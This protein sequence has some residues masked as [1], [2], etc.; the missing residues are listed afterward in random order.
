M[1]SVVQGIQR[2]L[3]RPQ[4]RATSFLPARWGLAAQKMR[5]GYASARRLL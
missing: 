1:V 4:R 5:F 2:P 3:S